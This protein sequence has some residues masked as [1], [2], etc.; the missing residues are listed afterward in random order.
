MFLQKIDCLASLKRFREALLV[1]DE[2]IDLSNKDRL[3]L[4]DVS[5][6]YLENLY[7][8]EVSNDITSEETEQKINDDFFFHP[9]CEIRTTVSKG[10]HYIANQFIPK[11]TVILREKPYNFELDFKYWTK[12][13]N[14][15]YKNINYQI[16]LC[17]ACNEVVFCDQRCAE[18]AMNQ[19]HRR[20]C[21]FDGLVPNTS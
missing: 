19:F 9:N 7:I 2:M 15:C 11:D 18:K 21:D 8:N 4:K 16:W 20:E 14:L 10:R 13:C 3:D 12:Y 1:I 5:I 17:I 6:Y